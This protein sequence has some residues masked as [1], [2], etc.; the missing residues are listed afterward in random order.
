MTATGVST[1]AGALLYI[2]TTASNSAT[3][4]YTAVGEVTSIPEFGR[5]Y[6]TVKY[7]PL[8]SRGTQKFKGSYDDG[9]VTIPMGKDLSDEGQA[10]LLL[11]RDTDFD[12]NFKVVDN[13]D[14]APATSTVGISVAT[15]G[16]VSLTAHGLAAGT[17]VQFA[18]G[19]GTLPTGLTAATTYYVCSGAT[20]LAN[21][22]S[23]ATSLVNATAGTGVATTGSAGVGNTMTTIP[24]GSSITFKAK[25]MSYTTERGGPDNV[26][27][28]KASLEIKSGSIAE[29]AHLP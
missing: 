29:T 22:F 9:A 11:A 25:V 15:P 23:I 14:V 21:T 16:L 12:Y 3:D 18:N 2:G 13:D 1:A 8:S 19:A 5:V 20:L 17:A 24:V 26:I 10:A 28:A 4:T 27:M 6:A 7:N